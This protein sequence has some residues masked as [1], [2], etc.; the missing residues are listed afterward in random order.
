[1]ETI[2][3]K[4]IYAVL[5]RLT[6]L[7]LHG[8]NVGNQLRL[9]TCNI[10]TP[11]QFFDASISVLR[12]Q[13]FKSICGYYWYMRLRGFEVDNYETERKTYGQQ[14]ALKHPTSDK[15]ELKGILMKLCEKMGR[16]LR[17][18]EMV[19][20]GIHIALLYDEFNHWHTGHSIKYSLYT[21]VELYKKALE[22]LE[23]APKNITIRKMSVTCFNLIKK[24]TAQPGLFDTTS[25]EHKEKLWHLWEAMD[26]VNNSY[27][28][29][30]V[31]TARMMDMNK[32][33]VDMI[34]FGNVKE[35]EL[36]NSL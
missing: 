14:Y 31:T 17:R 5:S 28:E 8:I 16:R 13:V 27:G 35:I 32:T 30:V 18:A 15:E 2:T 4:N 23:Q 7:D 25:F 1:L 6:L 11:L 29:Y 33:I 20:Q 3:H 21:T 34:A 22:I 10:Y 19:A 12:K 24:D 26:H 36:M 9:N